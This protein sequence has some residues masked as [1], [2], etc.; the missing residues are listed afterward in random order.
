MPIT[1]V[2][3]ECQTDLRLRDELAGK[4][5]RCPTCQE[6]FIVQG[7]APKVPAEVPARPRADVPTSTYQSGNVTDFVPLIAD[8]TAV[9]VP[10]PPPPP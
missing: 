3:P 2:C 10:K 4:M 8:A 9:P 6:A 7:V 1:A 5:V